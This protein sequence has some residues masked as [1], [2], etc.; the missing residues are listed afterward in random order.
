MV[1]L[2][3]PDAAGGLGARGG[4]RRP[5]GPRRRPER[6]GRER[7]GRGQQRPRERAW[8]DLQLDVLTGSVVALLG[9]AVVIALVGIGNTLGL[10]VLERGRENALLRALGLTRRQLRADARGGGGAAL[11]RG[12]RARHA[13]GGGFAWV[14]VQALVRAAIDEAPMVLPWGQ[15]ALVVLVAGAAGLVS[16]CSGRGVLRVSPARASAPSEGSTA[17]IRA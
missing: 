5:R 11:G 7:R 17:W 1:A 13:L 14:A 3:T 8:V 15:L 9:I 16:A 6:P 4:R 12:H 10:S 2:S